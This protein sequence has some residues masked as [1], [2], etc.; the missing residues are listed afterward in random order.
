MLP[1]S[2][3]QSW[4]PGWDVGR[5]RWAKAVP[6]VLMDGESSEAEPEELLQEVLDQK[7]TP[8]R[9]LLSNP[10]EAFRRRVGL[11]FL[12]LLR[13]DWVVMRGEK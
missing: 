10:R 3:G 11:L 7:W 9:N 4:H 2:Q 6:R 1:A 5:N 12:W 13:K 8:V